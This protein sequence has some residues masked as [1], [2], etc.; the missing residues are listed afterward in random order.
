MHK[1]DSVNLAAFD[2]FKSSFSKNVKNQVM[3][4]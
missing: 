2:A 3:F 1:N 4:S